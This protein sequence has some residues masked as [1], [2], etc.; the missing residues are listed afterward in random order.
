VV[1]YGPGDA[2]RS[3]LEALYVL[4]LLGLVVREVLE[5][6][7][8][9]RR[10]GAFAGVVTYV[11]DFG[12]IVDIAN[13]SMQVISNLSWLSF[14]VM[15]FQ[16]N[17]SLEYDVAKDGS[18]SNNFL[19][20]GAGFEDGLQVFAD[21][22]AFSRA[23]TVHLTTA[24]ISLVFC[25]T[26]LIKNLDF[27]PRMGLVSRTIGKAAT[28]M[29]FFFALFVAVVMIYSLLGAIQYGDSLAA[30]ESPSAAFQT[31]LVMLCGEFGNDRLD[32]ISVNSFVTSVYFWTFFFICFFI[33]VNAFLAIVVEAYEE[34]KEGFDEFS[35]TDAVVFLVRPTVGGQ[36]HVDDTTLDEVLD[37]CVLGG[38]GGEEGDPPKI[39]EQ[40]EGGLFQ[41]FK[42]C[43]LER[44]NR[45]V[46]LRVENGDTFEDGTV[47]KRGQRVFFSEQHL[48]AALRGSAMVHSLK[49]E[50]LARI[51]AHNVVERFGLDTGEREREGEITIEDVDFLASDGRHGGG[52]FAAVALRLAKKAR[53]K[54]GADKLGTGLLG[55]IEGAGRGML[56]RMGSMHSSMSGSFNSLPTGAAEDGEVER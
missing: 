51:V 13:Y 22:A 2:L 21:V 28:A 54:S 25:A 36:F 46:V 4:S 34:A 5:A 18:S 38:E 50:V 45:V 19:K 31:L 3:I 17:P 40:V 33:L 55:G 24:C 23:R 12:N 7:D 30:F 44:S 32:M 14:A 43:D 41:N 48:E 52:G 53:E 26:Q 16:W 56:T 39:L 10:F 35:Y 11:A 49:S 20:A 42:S 1:V 27:H 37:W 29:S 9:C 47:D 8:S 6:R 15:S